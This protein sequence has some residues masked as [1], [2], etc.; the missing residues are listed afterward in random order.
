MDRT[1]GGIISAEFVSAGEGSWVLEKV[2]GETTDAWFVERIFAICSKP[3]LDPKRSFGLKQPNDADG[4]LIAPILNN[5]NVSSSDTIRVFVIGEGTRFFMIEGRDG[6]YPVTGSIF[7]RTSQVYT[8]VTEYAPYHNPEASQDPEE[9]DQTD[10]VPSTIPRKWAKKWLTW[11]G[12]EL[13]HRDKRLSDI[14]TLQLSSE[15]GVPVFFHGS[16]IRWSP[17]AGKYQVSHLG[18]VS[19]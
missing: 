12:F 4:Y 16:C 18:Q 9:K 6:R 15:D 3:Y 11:T 10:R 2:Q 17:S 5:V 19:G 7:N 13:A 1:V 14:C 8:G